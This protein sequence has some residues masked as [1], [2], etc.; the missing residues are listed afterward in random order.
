M[1]VALKKRGANFWGL[2]PFHPEKTPSFSVNPAKA[3]FKCFGCSAGGNVFSFIMQ[4]EKM[5]FP[6]AVEFLARKLGIEIPRQVS[7]EISSKREKLYAAAQHGH[8]FFREMFKKHP[9]AA[10]YLHSRQIPRSIAE[11]MELGYAPPDWDAFAKTVRSNYQDYVTAGLLR[12]RDGGGHYDYFRHRLMFPIK[13]LAGRVCAFG[14]RIIADEKDTAKY[15][16]SPENPIYTKG[17]MLYGL[18]HTREA[19]RQAGF[20][21]LVEGYTDLLRLLSSGVG[22]AAAGLGTAFTEEQAK[23]LRR[24]TGKV[25]LLYDGDEAGCKAALRSA[26]ILLSAGMETEIITLPAE[27]DPDTFLLRQGAEGLSAQPAMSPI[28]FQLHLAGDAIKDR[29]QREAIAKEMLESAA[30]MNGEV[31][32]SLALEEISELMSIPIA[33][34]HAEFRKLRRDQR[35][36]TSETAEGVSLDFS[37][38]ELPE[39]DFLRLLIAHPEAG[40][41]VFTGLN[42]D[43]L[44]NPTLKSMFNN[45]KS[46]YLKGELGDIHTLINLYDDSRIQNFIAECAFWE[47]PY[48]VEILLKD[49]VKKL[50]D[51]YRRRMLTALQIQIKEAEE[52]KENTEA[53]LM[54]LKALT[55]GGNGR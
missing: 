1:Y 32:R 20:A 16:N 18:S 55:K 48:E 28:R 52:R 23:L 38:A 22:N 26:R 17:T 12:A 30:A 11:K 50:Q 44:T 37:P 4:K 51:N 8:S 54:K 40:E 43:L 6:E 53:L 10:N 14:G 15:I 45:M 39:R 47:A 31:K 9:D 35:D 27:D 7:P 49:A 29:Q 5:Q 34:L 41:D 2:C 21:Y 46:L 24:I 42:P 33:A 25:I 3:M 19:I 36:D 13:D